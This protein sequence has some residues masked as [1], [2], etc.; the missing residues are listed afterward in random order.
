M[1]NKQLVFNYCLILAV[2]AL[3]WALGNKIHHLE[4]LESKPSNPQPRIWAVLTE[5]TPHGNKIVLQAGCQPN[6]TKTSW[7]T[8]QMYD[9]IDLK[10]RKYNLYLVISKEPQ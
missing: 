2:G 9:N 7:S 1:K 3:I 8:E 6:W 5:T 4:R 10:K